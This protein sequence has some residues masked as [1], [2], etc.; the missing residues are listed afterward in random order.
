[1]G[2]FGGDTVVG[3]DIGTHTIKA[4][5]ARPVRGGWEFTGAA[6]VRTPA[7][8]I[9]D[10]MVADE[11]LLIPVLRQLLTRSEARGSE[12]VAA[13]N[14]TPAVAV[15]RL[16]LP[17]MLPQALRK[18][19]QTHPEQFQ[20]P[21]GNE[22]VADFDILGVEG[23]DE[24]ARMGVIFVTAPRAPVESR[25]HALEKAGLDPLAMDVEPLAL[26][27][28]L[29][30]SR[31]HQLALPGAT[32]LL[33]LG[34]VHTDVTVVRGA[35]YIFTRSIPFG[36]DGFTAVISQA[37][38]CTPDE[39][40]TLKTRADLRWLLEATAGEKEL[41]E[42]QATVAM[43]PVLDELLREV[44][45]SILF[46]QSQ[47]PDDDLEGMVGSIVLAGG[48]ALM[49]GMPEYMQAAFGLNVERADFTRG[50]TG[51]V[52]AKST[53]LVPELA[54]VYALAA[55]LALKE[56]MDKAR[57]PARRAIAK[58]AR[59]RPKRQRTGPPGAVP[60]PMNGT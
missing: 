4:V 25:F 51:A 57:E 18:Q 31:P 17:P 16:P 41:P 14:Y 55:G 15:R 48:T 47:L 35:D 20:L 3:L 40:E 6:R 12:V 52:S 10:G 34:A 9:V 24:N 53:E 33:D 21:G 11:K 36:G 26:V 22:T 49:A 43:K 46:Y 7:G 27:R 38:E 19:I 56:P 29:V 8:A 59:A 13:V 37:L 39:A 2:L 28:S 58:A 32:A 42:Y 44:R 5:K 23:E 45:N 54:P 1:M 50:S 30:E 60:T